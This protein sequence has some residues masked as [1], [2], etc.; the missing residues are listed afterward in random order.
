MMSNCR[1]PSIKQ[2]KALVM[3]QGFF[4]TSKNQK[5]ERPLLAAIRMRKAFNLINPAASS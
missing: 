4:T 1:E 5:K 2:K 3:D